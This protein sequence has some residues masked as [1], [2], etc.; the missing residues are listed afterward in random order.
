MRDH[1]SLLPKLY[2]RFASWWPLLSRPSDYA[3]EA[4]FFAKMLNAASDE[5]ARTM[6]ELGCGGGNS[7]SH[8]KADF[9]MTL[10]DLAPAMLDVSKKLNPECEHVEGDMRT[11]RLERQFDRV[12]VHDAICYMTT[13]GDLRMA[14]ETAF[15]HCRLGGS[16][17]FVPDHVRENFQ[18]GTD[19]GGHDGDGRGLR[20]LE[21][22]WDPDPSDTTYTVDYAYVLR[23]CDG[24][25]E[26]AHDRHIEGLFSRSEW[27]NLLSDVGFSGSVHA[28]EH[29]EVAPGTYELFI[30]VKERA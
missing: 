23:D 17:L 5:P 9:E 25:V 21:W 18:P 16:V 13:V 15:A 10:V 14:M 20:Y 1:N 30:G 4:L 27:L 24:S 22:T 28:V 7:A 26:V 6:L 11:V 2:D 8:L 3:E 12:F 29:S 19:C